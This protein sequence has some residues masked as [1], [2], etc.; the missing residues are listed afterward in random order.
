MQY[1]DKKQAE[2]LINKY[3]NSMIDVYKFVDRNVRDK[4]MFVLKGK[5]WRMNNSGVFKFAHWRH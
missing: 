2:S 1:Y 3:Q 5:N 4:V